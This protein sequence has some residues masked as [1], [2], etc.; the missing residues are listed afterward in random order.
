MCQAIANLQHADLQ[1]DVERQ[2]SDQ[3]IPRQSDIMLTSWHKKYDALQLSHFRTLFKKHVWMSTQ[4]LDM[5]TL[6]I[7]THCRASVDCKRC[8]K[9][10]LGKAH[11]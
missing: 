3:N 9:L 4:L 11:T 7:S 10:S 2:L 5:L 1:K 8:E 6:T